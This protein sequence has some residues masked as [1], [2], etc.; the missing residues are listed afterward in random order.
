MKSMTPRSWILLFAA[1]VAAGVFR[2][3][4]AYHGSLW[5]DEG[6]FLNAIAAPT[7]CGMIQ[8]L[9]THE[10]HP[11]LFYMVMRGW[12]QIAGENDRRLMLVPIIFAVAMVP[13]IYAVGRSLFG[14]RVGLIA[15]GLAAVSPQLTE[16]SSQIRPYGLL[17]IAAVISAG[18][19]VRC[20]T[21][22]TR[23][24]WTLFVIATTAMLYTH[25]WAWMIVAGEGIAVLYV[26]HRSSSEERTRLIRN[27]LVALFAVF[28]LYAPWLPSLVFQSRHAGHGSVPIERLSEYIGFIVL[29]VFRMLE[30]LVIGRLGEKRV[31]AVA[32]LIA[33]LA[34]TILMTLFYRSW[35]D[36][37]SKDSI[38]ATALNR[39]RAAILLR[40][41]LFSLVA[42]LIVSPFNNLILPRGVVTVA[43]LLLL[44][45]ARWFDMLIARRMGLN[46]ARIGA[47]ICCFAVVAACVENTSLISRPRSNVGQ[48]AN[49]VRMGEHSNDLLIVAPE[50]FA[51][52]F[53]HYFPASIEQIDYPY[54]GRSGMIDFTDIWENR[55]KSTAVKRIEKKIQEAYASN[56][57]V[58]FVFERRYMRNFT[59]DE[60]DRAYRHKQPGAMSVRDVRHI[61][62][63][64]DSIYGPPII[65]EANKPL[66]IN[67][68]MI[69]HLYGR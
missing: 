68:E 21:S 5:A 12:L 13:V 20:L 55:I 24:S 63:T 8:F 67:D 53:D 48:I 61:R 15:A 45:A 69:A 65:Y 46:Q 57:R 54:E 50:W 25:N 56:R 33:A 36:K 42:A 35:P 3:I 51:A 34:A 43:P 1:I 39:L 41:A 14:E 44:A 18:S 2:S 38:L 60:M 19:L 30:A 37:A 11:P 66:P 59:P 62:S 58:W 40:I 17:Y 52:S 6:S 49:T 10:S 16:H 26:V 32:G 64:L 23:T 7:W 28:V 47:I 29:S 27:C 31:V 4:V 9:R 22:R